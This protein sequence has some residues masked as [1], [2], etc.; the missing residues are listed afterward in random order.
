MPMPHEPVPPRHAG[1][2]IAGQGAAMANRM[3]SAITNRMAKPMATRWQQNAPNP[4]PNP[5]S[6]FVGNSPSVVLQFEGYFKSKSS[7]T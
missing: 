5:N 4:N 2:V 1:C 6:P 7:L 3:A